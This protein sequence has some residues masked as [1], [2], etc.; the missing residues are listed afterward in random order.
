MLGGLVAFCLL[1]VAFTVTLDFRLD[2]LW[3]VAAGVSST[4]F[5]A[6]GATLLQFHSPRALRGRVMSL[7]TVA[8]IG[9]SQLG[10]LL[11][12]AAATAIGAP[13]AVG[14]AAV[15]ALVLGLFVGTAPGWR[16]TSGIGVA[17]SPR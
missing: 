9:M 11:S 10:G 4:V 6:S 17:E 8:N 13:A 16:V 12:A 2:L 5:T 14:G 7:A 1:L 3:L 15:L